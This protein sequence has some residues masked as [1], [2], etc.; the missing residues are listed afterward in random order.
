MSTTEPTRQEV[1]PLDL[2]HLPCV[3][4]RWKTKNLPLYFNDKILQ[5]VEGRELL[6][7][8]SGGLSR[9]DEADRRSARKEEKKEEEK[10]TN[11]DRERRTDGRTD[12]QD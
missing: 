2:F 7:L 9:P 12:R 11:L 6:I 4:F 1:W 3:Q 8:L 10:E 5:S